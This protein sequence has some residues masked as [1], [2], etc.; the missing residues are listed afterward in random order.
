M[1]AIH[2]VAAEP[3]SDAILTIFCQTS[4]KLSSYTCKVFNG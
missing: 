4:K 2:G 3:L 1:E